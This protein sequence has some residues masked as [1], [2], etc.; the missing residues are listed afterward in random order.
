MSS[1]PRPKVQSLFSDYSVEDLVAFDKA[2]FENAVVARLFS[3]YNLD[4][5]I[6]ERMWQ[7]H[8]KRF[9]AGQLTLTAF[10]CEFPDFPIYLDCDKL[11]NVREDTPLHLLFTA[12]GTRK[13]AKRFDEMSDNLPSDTGACGLV[14]HWPY[15]G[16]KRSKVNEKVPAFVLHNRRREYDVPGVQLQWTPAAGDEDR[17]PLFLEP[18]GKL[19]DT[20]DQESPEG[21]WH[22]DG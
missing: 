11:R 7:E 13:I 9:G 4:R 16:S 20:I 15:L 19:L 5:R 8:A 21:K 18:L 2:K 6:K 1:D 22:P 10:H 12:F 17:E 14:F 3:R